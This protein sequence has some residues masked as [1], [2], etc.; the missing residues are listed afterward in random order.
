MNLESTEATG[1][2]RMPMGSMP[3]FRLE[4]NGFVGLS[5][6][7]TRFPKRLSYRQMA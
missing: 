2:F 6:Q 4:I 7:R 5:G 3:R 1:F